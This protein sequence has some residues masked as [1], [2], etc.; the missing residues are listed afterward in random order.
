MTVFDLIVGAEGENVEEI[1]IPDSTTFTWC[2]KIKC[3]HCLEEH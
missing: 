2:F 1:F 3:Q